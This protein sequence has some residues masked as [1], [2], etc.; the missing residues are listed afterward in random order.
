M[1]TLD[2]VFLILFARYRRKIGESN[3]EQAWRR[4]RHSVVTYLVF[5][6]ASAAVAL[7]TIAFAL[8][9]K[10]RHS[11]LKWWTQI[12]AIVVGVTCSQILY[13]RFNKY[14]A[15]VPNVTY[16]ETQEEQQIL[17][18]FRGI[19]IAVF[20]ATCLLAFLLSNSNWR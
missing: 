8:G 9:V 7:T 13:Q 2:T 1:K 16:E 18:W 15:A 12:V 4:A 3:L 5:P 19:C 11:D 6:I 20:V 17:Y 14:L 10:G